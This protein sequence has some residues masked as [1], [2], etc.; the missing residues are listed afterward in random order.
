[1]LR[2][3]K[4]IGNIE[5]HLVVPARELYRIRDIEFNRHVSSG[6]KKTA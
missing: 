2:A 3:R 4:R 6:H 5:L 1:L